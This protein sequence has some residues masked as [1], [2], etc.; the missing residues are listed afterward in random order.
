MA[1]PSILPALQ[2]AIGKHGLNAYV[3]PMVDE[4]QSEYVPEFSARLPR[5]TGF[6]GS[7]GLGLFRATL[8]DGQRHALLV[9]GRYTLQAA[10]EVDSGV[11]QVF[12]SGDYGLSDW[13]QEHMSGRRVGYDPWLI[14]PKQLAHWQSGTAAANIS[15]CAVSPNLVDGCWTDRPPAPLAAIALH[16]LEYA[17]VSY[18]EK[19]QALL[20]AMDKKGADALLIAQPDAVNWLLNLRGGDVPFNPL[21]LSY[22]ML[23][24]DGSATLWM[25]PRPLAEDVRHYLDASQVSVASTDT[26]FTAEHLGEIAATRVWIDPAVT[27]LGWVT[28]LTASGATTV[29]GEDPSAL[30][31]AI[32]NP[33]E[34]AGIRAAH[35]R[36]GLA[37]TRFLHGLEQQSRAG[38]SPDE[39][40]L[41]AQ[42]ETC[43]ALE[44]TY[45]GP[46]FATIA[47]SGPNG[48]IVHYRA[49]AATNRKLRP[50]ELLLIDSGGQYPDGTT[51]VT[52]TVFFPGRAQAKPGP[53][54]K[55][56]YTAVL[57][58]HIALAQAVF[59]RGTTGTQLDIL[60]RQFLWRDGLDFDH[61]TGH[62]VGAYLCVHEGPQRISKRGSGAALVPGMVLS[63]EPGYYLTGHYGIRIENLV[64]VVASAIP[65]MLAFETLTL[66]PI[67]TTLV[68]VAQLTA[69]DRNWLNAYHQRV[70]KTHAPSLDAEASAWLGEATRAI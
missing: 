60:A 19:R 40:G 14:T 59:P 36:D 22:L 15:W 46:S 58:G 61:G 17:G 64:M 48:A 2:D 5:V 54:V 16:P 42:L 56:H 55:R 24:R 49:S 66:A 53:E 13:M 37:L 43:R 25:R 3:L 9:D 23:R 45:R 1:H 63:N 44:P 31:K 35:R 29:E 33:I 32:K 65:G 57:K 39:L 67:D 27:P 6:H 18:G 52:R 11:T 51:D 70:Y 47:G 4:F 34:S 8:A 20:Q 26:L 28:L 30:M 68:E 12:N 10:A 50:G 62:G 7:A 69:D 21:L 41:V 38:H